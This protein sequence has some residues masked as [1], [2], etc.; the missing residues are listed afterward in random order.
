[1]KQPGRWMRAEIQEQPAVLERLWDDVRPLARRLAARW[2][3]DPPGLVVF[4]ARG[5]SDNAALYGRYLWEATLGVPVSLAAP[6][7]VTL[8]R[9]RLRLR[10]SWVVGLSQSGRSPD[11][12]TFLRRGRQGGAFTVAVT[13]DPDSPLA[14]ESHVVLP[15]YAGRERS[16]AATKTY[17]AELFVLSVLAAEAAKDRRLVS[18]HERLPGQVAAALRV[19]DAASDLARRWE[20]AAACV[21]TGRGYNYATAREAALK[22]KEAAYLPA[23]AL[24]SADF[25]HGPVALV[26]PGFPV[27]VVASPGR[28]RRH[29]QD[30]VRMLGRRGAQVA[31][32]SSDPAVLGCVQHGLEVPAGTPE[33]LT[34]HV[35]AVAV[36]LFSY[37]L[38][39]RRGTDPD[40]P[41][42]LRKVT[43]VL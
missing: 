33:E 31:V 15:L 11:V 13:N 24:S 5:S 26:G 20:G 39:V 18:A 7:V 32:V 25:L 42:G 28:A 22:L 10:G 9:G 4:V 41:R 3:L 38:G 6:S 40:R 21:V 16:V 1:M 30:V 36:Q 2:R 29:L 19:E 14:R 37:H 35:Y 8:Y 43:R 23:E 34:P 12:V 17:V 27:L